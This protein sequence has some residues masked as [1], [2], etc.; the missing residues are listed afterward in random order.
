MKKRKFS[1]VLFDFFIKYK[2][3]I[4]I[5]LIALIYTL[6]FFSGGSHTSF[7]HLIYIPIMLSS[8]FWRV[9][10]GVVIAIISGFLFGPLMPLT[11]SP[12][13]YQKPE[14]CIVRMAIFLLFSVLISISFDKIDE[15]NESMRLKDSISPL[16]GF[17]N[18]N[19]LFNY[20]YSRMKNNK[21]FSV[22]SIKFTNIEGIE[23]YVNPSLIKQIILDFIKELESYYSNDN[24]FSSSYNEIILV[25]SSKSDFINKVYDIIQNY[26]TPISIGNYKIQVI[27]KVGIYN[28]E[29]IDE[30]PIEVYNKARIAREQ[31]ETPH[32]GLYIYDPAFDEKRKEIY[33]IS[34]SMYDALMTDEFYLKFQPIISL[35]D[36]SITGVETLIRWDRGEDKYISPDIFIRIAEETGLIKD[37]TKFVMDK[38]T[39]QIQDWNAKG[40]NLSCAINLTALELLDQ[41]FFEETKTLMDNKKLDSSQFEF[42]L[43]ERVFIN[44]GLYVRELLDNLRES[45]YGLSIDDFGT[46]YNS[47]VSLNEIPFDVLKIDRYF[48]SRLTEK[49][50]QEL[51]RGI[52]IYAHQIG[53]TVIAE[54]VETQKQVTIL[55][56]LK[57]DRVQGFYYSK[58]LTAH[59]FEEYYENYSS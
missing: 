16:T 24:I 47:L 32:S 21:N 51:V 43:T 50:I 27:I 4:I 2:L 46:G 35:E 1:K 28:Y 57:C 54:G 36:E 40:I 49:D 59:E 20:L 55:K 37:I 26:S 34:G 33:E 38:G 10:G 19:A 29:G 31:G 52:I 9:K 6:V 12:L 18:Q 15:L 3:S 7:I 41:D 17:Y 25:C 30:E 48:I 53:K 23:K 8:Y 5:M 13:V 14:N 44:K 58:A 45:G 42:E 39:D 56:E 22:L 11:L